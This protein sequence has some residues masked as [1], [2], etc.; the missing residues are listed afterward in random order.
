MAVYWLAGAVFFTVV[1]LIV[2]GLISIWFALA[3]AITIF[4]S[5]VVDNGLYQGY[6]FVIL[7]AV[8]LASTRKFSK[9]M[10]ERKDGNVDRITG[11]VVEIKGIDPNGNYEI[12]FDGKHWVG[13]SDEKLE[14]GDKVK[15]LRIE[16]IKLVLEKIECKSDIE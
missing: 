10:L 12:Y 4:F 13:K 3:A 8:L 6:F 7:S 9:K 1:E 5:I 11:S 14:I 16:G 15:I 2:P